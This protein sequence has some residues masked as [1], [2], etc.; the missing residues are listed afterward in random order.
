MLG[1]AITFAGI[2]SA[3]A[4]VVPLAGTLCVL[5]IR[6]ILDSFWSTQVAATGGVGVNAQS[7]VGVVVPPALL[8]GLYLARWRPRA[9]PLTFAACAY[10]AV[11]AWGIV[12]APSKGAAMGDF[13]RLALPL[14]FLFSGEMLARSD[15]WITRLALVVTL[16]AVVAVVT[17][18]LQLSG[19]I[20]PQ[21]TA[22][23]TSGDLTRI[24]G[25]YHHPLDI[26]WRA[27]IS[28]PFALMFSRL[29]AGRTERV[30]MLVWALAA[31]GFAFAS[32]ARVALVATLAQLGVWLWLHGRRKS[33]LVAFVIIAGI[34]ST[35]PS[36]REVVQQAI[37]PLAEGRYYELG[38]GRGLLFV[39]QLRAFGAGNVV[40]KVLGRGLHSSPGLT[41][42]YNPLPL[43]DLG[44]PNAVEGQ[45]S[46]HNQLLRPLVECGIVG[47]ISLCV[48]FGTGL[49]AAFRLHARG[50]REL[51]RE[52]GAATATLL[53]GMIVYSIS[54]QPLD[55]PPIT[56]A[57]WTI[58]G[59][60]VALARR[61]K[62]A[63][64]ESVG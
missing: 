57:V 39:A 53:V 17:G 19:L 47:A 64:S 60:A 46:A 56:F 21:E 16:Y 3:L 36:L 18:M 51:D 61:A 22:V 32:L 1:L 52:F 5:A 50:T 2:L 8:A 11:C 26:A 7:I 40:Q 48:L 34:A 38:T 9:E 55:R 44:G 59:C 41:I 14:A 23:T 15:R 58:V 31:A 54:S 28:L 43:I 13:C 37:R 12:V 20:T 42:E 33:I 30:T 63:P 29:A 10:A 6:P 27:S 49:S 62:L 35:F 45:L 25:V 4:C 24:T